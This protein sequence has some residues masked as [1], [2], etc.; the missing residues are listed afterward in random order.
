MKTNVYL[1]SYA[2]LIGIILFSMSLAIATSEYVIAWMTRVGVYSE[3]IALLSVQ[4]TKVLV[5]VVFFTIYFMLF[6]A[7]KLVADTFNQLGFAFFARETNGSSLH[8]LKPGATIFLVGSGVSFLFLNSLLAAIGV[9]LGTFVLYLF[10]YIWQVS[11]LMS[12]FRAIG[13]LL[14][15]AMMW[16][17]LLSGLAW[18]LLRLF[19]SVG[20]IIL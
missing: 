5:L 16:A 1:L 18:A 20:D 14:I 12:T 7:F 17:L 8:R 9:L 13:L 4:E 10:Y 2:P 3:I 11:Q 15:Q 6:S 19:N